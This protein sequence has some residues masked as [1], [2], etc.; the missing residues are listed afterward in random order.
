MNRRQ[1]IKSAGTLSAV[2]AIAG[3]LGGSSGDGGFP[4]QNVTQIVPFST[5]GGFDTISRLTAPYMEDAL[6]GT[7][8]TENITGA[9]GIVAME[10]LYG[11]EPD[12]HTWGIVH[13]SAFA[14]EQ[15]LRET[16]Y[17]LTDVTWY[18]S[19]NE[20][21]YCVAVGADTGIDDM[22]DYITEMNDGN[23]ATGTVSMLGDTTFA[24]YL[25]GEVG[26]LWGGQQLLDNLVVYEGTSDIVTAIQRDEV[27]AIWVNYPSLTPWIE[28]G[29]IKV[30]MFLSM[31]NQPPEFLQ[32]IIRGNPEMIEDYVDAS[33]AKQIV[34]LTQGMR[35][36]AGPPDVPDDV[37]S[38][39]RTAFDE[40]LHDEEFL[41]EA[42]NAD[43]P[44]IYA[45]ADTVEE[46]TKNVFEYYEQNSDIIE[47][48]QD[49]VN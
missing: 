45:D 42:D 18:P 12:G 5:G 44:V 38:D 14:R 37:A 13:W 47:K 21:Y 28:S 36:F 43:F 6:G 8:E 25:V 17:D 24:P 41:T 34:N 31:G 2:G 22:E 39:I 4:E 46:R 49:A 7:I 3:C 33:A 19:C 29:D 26:G 15:F 32:D 48:L 11:A 10:E 40:V 35:A 30:L 9:G 1:V 20:F 16:D 27:Q 23:I